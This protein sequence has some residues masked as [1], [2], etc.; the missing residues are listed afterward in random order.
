MSSDPSQDSARDFED[1]RG[2]TLEDD[3]EATLLTA[4]TEC[5]MIWLAKDGHP[6]G[7]IV[8]YIFRKDRFWLTATEVR[9]RIAAL[10][11]DPRISIAIS[12]KGS[13]VVARQSVTYQGTAVLHTDEETLDWFIPEFSR[14]MRPDSVAAAESFGAHLRSP[15]RVVIEL[16]PRKR[17]GFDSTKMWAAAPSAAPDA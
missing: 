10:R 15:G 7:V 2:Y 1:V 9:P 3:D 16:V 12:S 4:Q 17:V 13:G 8:N 11:Q 6:M 14:A 5:T